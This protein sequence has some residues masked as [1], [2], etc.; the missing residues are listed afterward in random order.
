[1]RISFISTTLSTEEMPVQLTTV[2]SRVLVTLFIV[3]VDTK[4]SV[5]GE[6][7]RE[8]VKLAKFIII[9]VIVGF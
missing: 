4:G 1:M 3:M 7:S 5:P 6:E 9:G 8:N 2:L